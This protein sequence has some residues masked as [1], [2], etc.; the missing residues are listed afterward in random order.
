MHEKENYIHLPSVVAAQELL[1]EMSQNLMLR[2]FTV[3]M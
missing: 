3:V 1:G 2:G